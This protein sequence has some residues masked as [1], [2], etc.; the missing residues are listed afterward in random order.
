MQPLSFIVLHDLIIYIYIYIYIHVIVRG[1]PQ[2][3]HY[4]TSLVKLL[5]LLKQSLNYEQQ[6]IINIT[7]IVDI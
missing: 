6:T 3:C 5:Q 4:D 7:L 2:K 1:N